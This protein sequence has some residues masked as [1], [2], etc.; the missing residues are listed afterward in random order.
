MNAKD[1]FKISAFLAAGIV[2]CMGSVQAAEVQKSGWFGWTANQKKNTPVEQK[3]P[4]QKIPEKYQG[5]LPQQNAEPEFQRPLTPEENAQAKLTQQVMNNN[6]IQQQQAGPNAA[7]INSR[8]EGVL[9]AN[10]TLQA[11]QSNQAA[12]IQRISERARQQQQ[13]LQNLEASK[14]RVP[15]VSA[16]D[17]GEIMRQERIRSVREQAEQNQRLI[18]SLERNRAR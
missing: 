7:E 8:I 17:A 4:A 6:R 12:E 2:V 15:S 14:N 5:K 10:E 9:R 11:A 3:K 18:Q 1:K 13:I 16:K